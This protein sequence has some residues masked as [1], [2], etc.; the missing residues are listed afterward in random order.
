MQI[1]ILDVIIKHETYIYISKYI[2]IY[3]YIYIYTHTH[4]NKALGNT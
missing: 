4:S 3:I 1:S 2:Y